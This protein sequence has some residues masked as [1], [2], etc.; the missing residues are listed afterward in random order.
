VKPTIPSAKLLVGL[1]SVALVAVAA[2]TSLPQMQT[3]GDQASQIQ[4]QA[5]Q[6]AQRAAEAEAVRANPAPVASALAALEQSLPSHVNLDQVIDLVQG[7]ADRTSVT[8]DRGN[9]QPVSSGTGASSTPA[10][11]AG[12]S[13]QPGPSAANGVAQWQMPIQVSGTL[14]AVGAF[15]DDL[16]NQ[17]RLITADQ[18]ALQQT[19]GTFTLI[20][21][22]HFYAATGSGTP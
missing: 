11:A 18:V 6:I 3:L 5:Q 17:S 16:R 15:L 12:A 21:T 14:Q 10:A 1:A 22:L 9:P 7:A 13:A 4:V 2:R 20:V 8:W 19:N